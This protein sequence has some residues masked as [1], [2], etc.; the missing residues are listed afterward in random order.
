VINK[1]RLITE[2]KSFNGLQC[3][4]EHESITCNCIMRFAVFLPEQ[5]SQRQVPALYWLSGLTCTEENFILKSGAQRF[6]AEL[7][8]ALIVPDTSPRGLNLPGEK[9]HMELG[10]GAGFYVN[11]TEPPWA[12][13]YQMY[14]YV[15]QELVKTV[16]AFLPIDAERKSISGHSMGGHGALLACLRQ[17]NQ[18][19]SVSAFSPICTVSQSE[20]GSR[21]LLQY[22]GPDKERWYEY[23]VSKIIRQNPCH[24]TILIDQGNADPFL[25]EL[26]PS[27]LKAACEDS[28]QNLVYR[29]QNGYD[30]SYFFISTFIEDHLRFHAKALT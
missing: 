9:K 10:T 23:D 7:G 13:H 30:H 28:G 19:A 15:T 1:P 27:D 22:L 3:T 12:S 24:H 6:A 14:D 21:A 16:N 18:Y 17:P 29:E 26:R 25:K 8:L 11:A 20:W 5:S 4:Y 2:T